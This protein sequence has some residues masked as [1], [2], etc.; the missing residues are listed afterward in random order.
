MTQAFEAPRYALRSGQSKYIPAFRKQP[1]QLYHLAT[2]PAEQHNLAPQ[3][4]EEAARLRTRLQQLTA[5][6]VH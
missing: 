2:D 3:Q 5:D 1:E 6:S 4:P